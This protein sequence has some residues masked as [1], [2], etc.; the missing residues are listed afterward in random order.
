[1]DTHHSVVI[2]QRWTGSGMCEKL[3]W[4]IELKKVKFINLMLEKLNALDF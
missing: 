4:I 3:G 1:M 2:E